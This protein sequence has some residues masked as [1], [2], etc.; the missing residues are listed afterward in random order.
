MI[1]KSW[2]QLN[3]PNF[4]IIIANWLACGS[5]RFQ[6]FSYHWL[7]D[8]SSMTANSTSPQ[9][10]MSSPE[11]LVRIKSSWFVHFLNKKFL[12]GA[13]IQLSLHLTNYWFISCMQSLL[14]PPPQNTTVCII[15]FNGHLGPQQNEPSHYSSIPGR[16]H[17]PLNIKHRALDN[18]KRLGCDCSCRHRT[19]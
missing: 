1:C 5:F 9:I 19:T 17:A 3:W 16:K 15:S 7:Q 14:E 11:Q 13:V 8:L 2:I 10:A 12:C 18:N 6:S 4:V